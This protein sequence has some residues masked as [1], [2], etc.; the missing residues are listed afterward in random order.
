MSARVDICR[1]C[2]AAILWARTPQGRSMPVDPLPVSVVLD[3]EGPL[4]VVLAGGEV[5]RAALDQRSRV[6]GW[7]PHWNTCQCP[8]RFRRKKTKKTN[9]GADGAKQGRLF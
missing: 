2:G 1:G 8:Q 7:I 6:Q 5:A 4:S 9:D 3:R